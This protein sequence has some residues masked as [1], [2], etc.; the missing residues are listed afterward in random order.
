LRI[1]DFARFFLHCFSRNRYCVGIASLLAALFPLTIS[2]RRFHAATA[3]IVEP[4]FQKRL[5]YSFQTV[6]TCT[7]ADGGLHARCHARLA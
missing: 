6:V 1:T 2:S 4:L 3:A 5:R 7:H